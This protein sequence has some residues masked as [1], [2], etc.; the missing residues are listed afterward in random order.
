MQVRSDLPLFVFL[1]WASWHAVSQA[2]DPTHAPLQWKRGVI[3][4]GPPGKSQE[5]IS[6]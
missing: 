2:R 5:V 4:T 1:L 6:K 3:T